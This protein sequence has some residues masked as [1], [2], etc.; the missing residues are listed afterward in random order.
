MRAKRE[1]GPAE[2]GQVKRLEAA[3]GRGGHGWPD[4]CFACPRRQTE[5]RRLEPCMSARRRCNHP[6][7]DGCVTR[8]PHGRKEAGGG[9]ATRA[10]PR[11]VVTP[12]ATTERAAAATAGWSCHTRA[13]PPSGRPVLFR[14]HNTRAPATRQVRGG[15]ASWCVCGACSARAPF[16]YARPRRRRLDRQR[17][18]GWL[19]AEFTV[20]LASLQRGKNFSLKALRVCGLCGP[21]YPL[22]AA[23]ILF[24]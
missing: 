16:A 23:H 18:D 10:A 20:L 2:P 7:S 21:F 14:V 3:A 9:G 17:T 4:I 11:P 13:R 8:P 6:S 22:H 24:H 19:P 12:A 1:R 5:A 15:G